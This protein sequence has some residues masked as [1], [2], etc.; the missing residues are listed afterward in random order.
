MLLDEFQDTDPIQ[1]ELAV[2][3]AGGRAADTDHWEDVVIPDGRVFVV[4]DAKQSIY[5]FRRASI[6]TYLDAQEVIG[7]QVT[8]SSNFRSRPGVVDWVNTVFGQL[9]TFEPDGQPAYEALHAHRTDSSELVGPAVAVLGAEELPKTSADALRRAEAASVAGAIQQILA[10]GWS[11]RDGDK[12]WRRAQPSDIAILLP[13]RASMPM[14]EDALDTAGIHFRAE[15]MSLVYEAPEVRELLV[16][17]RAIA[18]PSDELALVSAL[19]SPLFACGDDDLWRWKH[20]GSR[21]SLFTKTDDPDLAMSPVGQALEY[22]SALHRAARWMTPSEVLARI[23]DDRRVLEVGALSPR[24]RDTWRRVRFVIDQARAWAEVSHGGLRDYV[25]W[26][27]HQAQEKARVAEAVLPEQ[28]VDAVRVM[29][30]HAAKGLEFPIVVMSGM[31]TR[32]RRN[33]GVRLLWKDD[34]YSVSLN[35]D[36]RDPSFEDLAALDEQMG[37]LERT[38]LLYVAATRAEDHLVVSLHREQAGAVTPAALIAGAGGATASD[39]DVLEVAHATPVTSPV[40][41]TVAPPPEFTAWE[42]AMARGRATSRAMTA[43]TASG[44]EGTEPEIVMGEAAEQGK[45]KGLRNLELPPWS[46]GRYGSAVGR[47]VHGVLQVVDLATGAGL[48]SAVRSQVLAEGIIELEDTVTALARAA[49]DSDV[50]IR[51]AQRQHWREVYVGAPRADG[52][53]L[54]GVIDLLYREDDGSYVVVDYKTDVV[55]SATIDE[56]A[57]FYRPQ[58]VAYREMLTATVSGQ[59][60][61]RLLFLHPDR[62]TPIDV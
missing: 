9:I 50:V 15:A 60:A 52:T 17:A 58:L 5:R 4:G 34:D 16:A 42:A 55:S 26:V 45:A 59:I 12:G 37:E 49:L 14:L 1:I 3:I 44:L 54:E 32:P 62:A 22:L 40:S 27:A 39:V 20:S 33:A 48:E 19:R 23:V 24:M 35:K 7:N 8:L 31:T 38:R 13:S 10:E 51:A 25:E 11:V 36:L 30:V 56:R 41:E 6:K 53:L 61:L 47:A 57:V 43:V 46:K 28:D 21:F 2:R 18:D 29:T